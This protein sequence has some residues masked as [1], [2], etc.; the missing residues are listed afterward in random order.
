MIKKINAVFT[1]FTAFFLLACS[2]SSS[3]SFSKGIRVLVYNDS[4][5]T[6]I[7]NAEVTFFEAISGE[8]VEKGLQSNEEG[9]VELS[10]EAGSYKIEINKQGFNKFPLIKGSGVPVVLAENKVIEVKYYL[11]EIKEASSLGAL[12]GQLGLNEEGV[13]LIQL[14]SVNGHYS[15]HSDTEGAYQFWNI[16]KGEYELSIRVGSY[17][18]VDTVITIENTESNFSTELDPIEGNILSGSISFL[19][20]ENSEVDVTLVDPIT[21]EAIPG[22]K[23]FTVDGNY[24]ISGIPSGEY[25]VWASYD[26]DGYVV[27]P[28]WIV[29]NGQPLVEINEDMAMPFSVTGAIEILEPVLDTALYLI[30]ELLSGEVNFSWVAYSSSDNYVIEVKDQNGKVVWGGFTADFS[31]RN[32][33]LGK[34][35]TNAE[36]NFD[37][38]GAA[39][40]IGQVY[41]YKIYAS[42]EDKKEE[43]GFK[44]ISS[45]EDNYGLFKVIEE[46]VEE[47]SN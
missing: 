36:Y 8:L 17:A 27:D 10:L 19:A 22:L 47:A 23:T 13:A 14:K 15:T 20:S 42:K 2:D 25:L 33:E 18:N 31:A 24:E 45:S 39:L 44:L 12:S 9:S 43:S 26:I 32:M 34:A 7:S 1:I 41:S 16:P 40:K 28:D 5:S 30:P 6:L 11:S 21:K 35:E 37:N 46:V 38:N 29:K 3:P 4:D